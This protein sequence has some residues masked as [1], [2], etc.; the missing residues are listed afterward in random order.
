MKTNKALLYAALAAALPLALHA[1][2]KPLADGQPKFL[3]GVYSPT[4]I[5]DFASY[6]NKVTPE[7]SGKW[8]EVEAVRD[9]M[10]FTALDAAYK[11]A[12]QHGYPFHMH[13]MVWGNQ[14][15]E[16]MEKLPPAEQR[17]EIEEWLAA[18]AKRY[19]DA[20]FV[21][22][23]NEPLNDPPSKDDEGGGNYI[24]ALGG[25]GASGWDWIVESYRMARRYFPA[26]KLLINDYN[27]TNK[28]DATRRCREIID[29][30]RKDNLVDGIGVQAH[31][32][33]TKP[34]VP[35]SVHKANLD[36]LAEKG[37]PIYVTELDI[38]GATD[39][40]QLKDYQRI[41]PVF[42]EH[43]AVRGITMWGYR[44]GLWR[45]KEGA[46]LVRAD[47][48]ERPALKWLRQYVR[49]EVKAP[50]LAEAPPVIGRIER[51]DPAF[52]AVV[53]KG[54]V[55]EQLAEGFSWAEGPA[56]IA[57]GKY[58]LFSDVP[59]NTIYRWSAEEG[60]GIFEKPSG[61]AGKPDP[62]MREAGANGLLPTG[63][64]KLLFADSGNRAVVRM[65]LKSRERTTLASRYGGKRLN[66]PNDLVER[67]DGN[68]YFTDPPYG[69]AGINDSPRK[70]Q[71]SNGVY[72]LARDGSVQLVDDRLS[73]PN[74]IALSPDQNTLYVSNTDA[75]A[76]V[77][78]AYALDEGGK[79]AARREFANA[80]DL[81]G[82]DAPGL[83]D[84]MCV[85]T[86]GHL[87]ATAPGGVLLLAPDG[88]RLGL[89]AT[90]KAVSNCALD[91]DGRTLYLTS[92]DMLAR[93]RLAAP[94]TEGP[95]P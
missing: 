14:Q 70:E 6:W 75:K 7:N 78:M 12:R 34:G 47:G 58:L 30:L 3:G 19:P 36:V 13:V 29:L 68:V 72:R 41:F 4:Q 83:P 1:Q 63:D 91:D 38:D 92:V 84:G 2:D 73:M 62:A 24:E 94:P 71:K 65:D 64:G 49:G 25:S 67:R 56:W 23:V 77:W 89:I 15:P 31:A 9:R 52:D 35:M 51:F 40:Q 45:E 90:G 16:W 81:V 37:L 61:Y 5:R 87:F 18:V 74:G 82:P 79:V 53:P 43:P 66:S 76:P 59:G 27:I 42:W 55:V 33:E 60:L 69:L 22:V 46:M 10:D 21:E 17:K 50:A 95:K 85:T 80:S 26:S 54:A 20:D 93:V 57:D 39:V 88:K 86:D 44:P 48:S 28:P 8:G 11:F 32:F